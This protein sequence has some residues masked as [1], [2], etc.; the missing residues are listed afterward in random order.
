MMPSPAIGRTQPNPSLNISDNIAERQQVDK[1]VLEARKMLQEAQMEA[2]TARWRLE[3]E[4][5]RRQALALRRQ[6]EK[7]NKK[8]AQE[9]NRYKREV[10]KMSKVNKMKA[11]CND[12]HDPISIANTGTD[13]NVEDNVEGEN[14]NTHVNAVTIDPIQQHVNTVKDKVRSLNPLRKAR[15]T[16]TGSDGANNP[17]IAGQDNGLNAWMDAQLNEDEIDQDLKY[18]ARYAKINSDRSRCYDIDHIPICGPP[19]LDDIQLDAS[20]EEIT[21]TANRMMI[22]ENMSTCRS[23]GILHS[24]VMA[25]QKRPVTATISSAT[26]GKRSTDRD[27][28]RPDHHRDTYRY[29]RSHRD[30]YRYE[31]HDQEGWDTDYEDVDWHTEKH[32]KSVKSIDRG[33]DLHYR[34]PNR[35][36]RRE[37]TYTNDR[38]WRGERRGESRDDWRYAR[39]QSDDRKRHYDD[40]EHDRHSRED[41]RHTEI[42]RGRKNARHRAP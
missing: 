35:Y 29:P 11:T 15:N 17:N 24:T 28:T 1:E 14:P 2:E 26:Q 36:D 33:Y 34:S 5:A 4:E 31:E 27:N 21:E 40:K 12:R 30:R 7:D 16:Y 23:S 8:A 6:V 10:K 9:K 42:N 41:S 18:D 32:A 37:N 38:A 13:N 25:V 20:L 19:K 39:D 3:V 22:D